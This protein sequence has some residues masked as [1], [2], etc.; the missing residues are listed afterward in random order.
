VEVRDARRRSRPLEPD[1]TVARV[2]P[3]ARVQMVMVELDLRVRPADELA[4]THPLIQELVLRVGEPARRQGA[5]A[6][7]MK[8]VELVVVVGDQD[9]ELGPVVELADSDVLAVAAVALV[10]LT[11]EARVAA[12]ALVCVVTRPRLEAA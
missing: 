12:G 3:V 2:G 10:A 5:R 7:V 9:L 4:P 11:I 1:L 6:V 8:D